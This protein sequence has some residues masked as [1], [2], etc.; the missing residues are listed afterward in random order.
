MIDR[1]SINPLRAI[2]LQTTDAILESLSERYDEVAF[3][4][5]KDRDDDADRVIYYRGDLD[6]LLGLCERLKSAIQEAE[7]KDTPCG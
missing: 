4:A 1:N 3:I 2:P 7:Q 6:V 5:R